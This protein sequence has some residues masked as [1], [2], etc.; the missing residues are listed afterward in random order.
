MRTKIETC[1]FYSNVLSKTVPFDSYI[2]IESYFY[3]EVNVELCINSTTERLAKNVQRILSDAR[4]YIESQ[5]IHFA[6]A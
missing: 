6:T 1:Y 5:T 3:Q 2:N 4:P